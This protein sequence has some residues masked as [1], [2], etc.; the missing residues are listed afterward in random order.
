MEEEDPGDAGL[1]EDGLEEAA[2]LSRDSLESEGES[3]TA[4]MNIG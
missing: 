1:K 4:E 2:V 3:G